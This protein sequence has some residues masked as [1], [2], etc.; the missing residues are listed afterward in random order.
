MGFQFI[1][2]KTQC[3]LIGLHV[4]QQAAKVCG[5]LGGHPAVLV[6]VDRFVCHGP[7]VPCSDQPCRNPTTCR[8]L[9]SLPPQAIAPNP[10]PGPSQTEG[11]GDRS[12]PSRQ[13]MRAKMAPE[14]YLR[15]TP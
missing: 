3:A 4:C 11:P 5:F 7:S 9:V 10:H 2:P 8:F 15:L 1:L 14:R 12:L 13:K 6:K